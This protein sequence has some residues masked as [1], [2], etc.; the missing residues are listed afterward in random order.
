[1]LPLSL[2]D[3]IKLLVPTALASVIGPLLLRCADTVLSRSTRGRDERRTAASE[4]Q[5]AVMEDGDVRDTI[6]LWREEA[7]QTRNELK[8]L[9]AEVGGLRRELRA[10]KRQ[11]A[12][13]HAERDRLRAQ[14]A[15]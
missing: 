8:E 14:I 7:Q 15:A 13:C 2:P 11:L 10:S 5:T 3:I 12:D 4:R 9:R 1:M 6:R